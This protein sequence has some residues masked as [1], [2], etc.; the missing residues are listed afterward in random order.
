M[1]KENAVFV[2]HH[3][4]Y[5]HSSGVENCSES[6]EV[7]RT[8]DGAKKKLESIKN[9]V[10]MEL[11]N[12]I[13]DSTDLSFHYIEKNLDFSHIFFIEPKELHQ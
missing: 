10:F 8:I 12:I 3:R 6:I 2:L 1:T 9:N 13:R 4:F 11:L 5:D 7:Y